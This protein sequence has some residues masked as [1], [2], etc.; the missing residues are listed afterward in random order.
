M[1]VWEKNSHN[2]GGRKPIVR[3]NRLRSTFPFFMSTIRITRLPLQS[4]NA[5]EIA[6]MHPYKF[7]YRLFLL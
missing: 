6:K 4:Y 1:R 3:Y 7:D 2:R 5:F